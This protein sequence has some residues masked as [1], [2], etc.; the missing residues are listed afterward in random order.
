M[1]E[2][3]VTL[4][5]RRLEQVLRIADTVG[6][7]G[8][9]VTH[10]WSGRTGEELRIVSVET[11]TPKARDFV[12]VLESASWTSECSITTREVRS[13]IDHTEL[14][15]LT[16]TFSE[17][18]P[19]IVQD[20]WQLSDITISYVSRAAAGGA[21]LAT[22]I[23]DNNPIAIVVAALSLPFLST[24]LALSLGITIRDGRLAFRGM[25]ALGVSTALT[26]TAAI[27]VGLLQGGPIGFHGFKSPLH[28]LA[29]SA[30]I[31]FTA[32]LSTAGDTGRR[33][34]IGVAA[35][36]QLAVFPAWLGVALAT[37][38][39]D[40]ALIAER[41]GNFAINTVVITAAAI[42]AY[43]VLGMRQSPRN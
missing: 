6:I 18:L 35:A 16:K 33:Y 3:R 26:F 42:L 2:V 27:G 40:A 23:L 43:R 1:H 11:S 32:G 34:L 20:L 21:L 28:N 37:S 31:G 36:V 17:P 22:G 12:Q 9:A 41:L 5:P 38:A 8:A 25:R 15:S 24:V 29:I 10:A 4:N 19:E 7:D 14:S 39:P 30:A 13:I